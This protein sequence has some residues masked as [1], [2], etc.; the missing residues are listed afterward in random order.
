MEGQLESACLPTTTHV[1]FAQ[2]FDFHKL[3]ASHLFVASKSETAQL[4]LRSLQACA[5]RVFRQI[6]SLAGARQDLRFNDTW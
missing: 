4:V 2:K 1:V 3:C 6:S 5:L